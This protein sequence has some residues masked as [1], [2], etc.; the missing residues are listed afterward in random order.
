M[1]PRGVLQPFC[2]DD[3]ILLHHFSRRLSVAAV[4]LFVFGN[5]FDKAISANCSNLPSL[6]AQFQRAPAVLAVA[7]LCVA[8]NGDDVGGGQSVCSVALLMFE[9]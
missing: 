4:A 6:H 5:Q 2:D 3:G 9:L 8:V 7:F 1:A